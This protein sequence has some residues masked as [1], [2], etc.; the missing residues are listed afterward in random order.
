MAYSVKA[1]PI[2][3]TGPGWGQLRVEIFDADAC[4]VGEYFRSY[5]SMNRTFCAFK[6]EDREFA[7]YA[8]SAY[9]TRVM[10]LPDCTDIGGEVFGPGAFCPTDYYM[11][12]E[13]EGRFGFV[14]GCH[15]GDDSSWKVQFLDLRDPANPIRLER[16]GYVAMP[17]AAKKLSEVIQ[18]EKYQGGV[19]IR[20]QSELLVAIEDEEL[21]RG[22]RND[23][24]L[25]GLAAREHQ[26]L[27]ELRA[28]NESLKK[29]LA[30]SSKPDTT[31]V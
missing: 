10:T 24:E 5:P 17:S 26:E 20:I 1:T 18:I 11:P 15:W 25:Y 13:F 8:P 22:I 31:D 9:C 29:R 6:H 23:N 16:F 19:E 27:R 7:L 3:T 30:E 14:A 2:A 12:D 28:E 4:K 21:S